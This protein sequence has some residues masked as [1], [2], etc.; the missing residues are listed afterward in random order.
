MIASHYYNHY[1]YV[2]G[3]TWFPELRFIIPNGFT[4]ILPNE[5]DENTSETQHENTEMSSSIAN[6]IAINKSIL[7]FAK[8]KK[9]ENTN[10]YTSFFLK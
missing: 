9:R 6:A 3:M 10:F 7:W 4:Y 8:K 2:K 1:V 5:M